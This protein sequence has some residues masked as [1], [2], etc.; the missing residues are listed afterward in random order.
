MQYFV[1]VSLWFGEIEID[2][3]GREVRVGGRARSLQPQAWAVL[4]YLVAHLDRVVT[5]DEL[6]DRLWGGTHVTG[7]S[8]RPRDPA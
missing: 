4:A 7:V 1:P 2:R 5:K 3:D 8:Y 6:L